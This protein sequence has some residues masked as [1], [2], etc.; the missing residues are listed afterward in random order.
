MPPVEGEP[1]EQPAEQEFETFTDA[2]DEDELEE[3]PRGSLATRLS[4]DVA[5]LAVVLG[6]AAA[7]FM[8]VD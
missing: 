8:L 5:I 6:T 3:A 7:L 2:D 4:R 1:M